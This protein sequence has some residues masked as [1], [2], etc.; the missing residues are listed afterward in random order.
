MAEL[1]GAG[2]DGDKAGP[3]RPEPRRE[4]ETE[5]MAPARVGGQNQSEGREGRPSLGKLGTKELIALAQELQR[6]A[7]TL[8]DRDPKAL[9]VLRGRLDAIKSVLDARVAPE[10]EPEAIDDTT[11]WTE[12]ALGTIHQTKPTDV[13]KPGPWTRR[14]QVPNPKRSQGVELI[15][16]GLTVKEVAAALGVPRS[17]VGRWRDWL[18]R[19]GEEPPKRRPAPPPW[20]YPQEVRDKAWQGFREANHPR[21][22][23]GHRRP[24][25]DA[26]RVEEAVR[27]RAGP[28]RGW[29]TRGRRP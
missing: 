14:G 24:Q 1:K 28:R 2:S 26:V 13:G 15:R 4:A 16:A 7:R 25:A 6:Q 21:A 27:S 17:T 3:E 11:D 10:P 5:G 8:G 18:R 12:W 9:L 29:R 20:A 22:A 23:R 19:Q